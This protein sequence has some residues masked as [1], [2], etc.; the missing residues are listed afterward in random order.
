MPAARYAHL[1]FEQDQQLQ[2]VENNPLLREKVRLRA[3]VIRL[4]QRGMSAS[5]I[6]E[7]SGR[8]YRSIIRDLERWEERGIEGLS[9]GSA[10]G[11]KSPLG[12]EQRAWLREKLTEEM[13]HTASDL[14][15][16]LRE[17]FNIRANRESVRACLRELGYSW[18]RNRYV[19][20][21]EVDPELLHEHKASLETLKRGHTKA[22][23]S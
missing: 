19:P 12:E 13:N 1:T 3:R 15:T 10:P 21:K 9:D 23:S 4:S 16:G 14:A 20:V 2:K 17:L 7:Y 5:K 18:Q 11:N 22:G 8:N 6:S